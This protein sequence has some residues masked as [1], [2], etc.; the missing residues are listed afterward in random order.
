MGMDGV[1]IK[2]NKTFVYE[3]WCI[4]SS[5]FTVIFGYLTT[6][7]VL[8]FKKSFSC[9]KCDYEINSSAPSVRFKIKL[10]KGLTIHDNVLINKEF[11][12]IFVRHVLCCHP[13]IGIQLYIFYRVTIFFVPHTISL[14]LPLL[15]V[16]TFWS[17]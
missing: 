17:F 13:R 9:Q 5:H 16:V 8:P 1:M 10:I 3:R 2:A 7:I 15:I 4:W 11:T 6:A 12:L 14:C